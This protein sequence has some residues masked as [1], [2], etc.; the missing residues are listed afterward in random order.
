MG[1]L[2]KLIANLPEVA[3]PLQKQLAFKDKLKWTLIVLVLFFDL[4]LVPLYGL[5]ANALQR[6]EFISIILGAS[7]GSILSLGIGPLVTASIVLQLLNGAGLVKFDMTDKEGR[8][9]FQGTQ[10][11]LSYGFILFEAAIYVFMSGLAPDP[12]LAATPGVYFTMQLVLVAQL[13][14][15]GLVVM[16]LDE[17]VSKWGFGSGISL[18]IAA[19]VSQSLFIR[20]FSPLPSPTNPGVPTGAIPTLIQSLGSGEPQTAILML[21]MIISTVVIFLAAVYLQAM[22]VEIPLSFGRVRG[23][24]IRWPLHFV[25]TSNIPVI[26][27]AALIAN[28]QLFAQL[29]QNWGLPLLGTLQNGSPSS[30]IVALL[31]PPNLLERLVHGSWMWSDIGTGLF[32]LVFLVGGSV[33][34]SWFW[35]QTAGMDSRSQAKQI[36]AS[37]LQLPGFRRDERV[38]ERLLD[39]Y[40]GPLTIMGAISVGLLAGVADVLGALTHGTSLLLTVMI[41]YRLYE[42]IAR[43]HLMDMNPMMRK[44]MGGE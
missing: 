25:Y 20:A 23:H 34:F 22:K 36:M 1:A 5:G 10:K 6:F 19:G 38:L 14:L 8:K 35:V 32:Y 30:G 16:F 17:V 4:G 7:F 28:V 3:G 39:R 15:G 40:I 12:N 37:G 18:F 31:S 21:G 13:A 26:L 29:L 33:L 44:F 43:Q 41:V 11:L 9:R 27:I 42:D 24:G 2:D